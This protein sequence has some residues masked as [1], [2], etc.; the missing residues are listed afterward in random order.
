MNLHLNFPFISQTFCFGIFALVKKVYH[1]KTIDLF[2]V[3]VTGLEPVRYRYRRILSP[4]RL[5][6]PS[7]RQIQINYTVY[8][9]KNQ[10]YI[11]NL[12]KI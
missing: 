9:I 7:H 5:P 4:L 10:V 2:M 3:P 8:I 11:L 12:F 1:L 6:I